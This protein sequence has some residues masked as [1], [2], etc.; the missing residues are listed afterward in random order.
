MG[1]IIGHRIDYNGVGEREVS[2]HTLQKL[3]QVSPPP[4]PC[5]TGF[6]NLI[7][8]K[9]DIWTG[10]NNEKARAAKISN[11]NEMHNGGEVL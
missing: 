5:L 8:V 10:V 3:T 2:A 7:K 11:H 6:P 1:S 4:P 9:D